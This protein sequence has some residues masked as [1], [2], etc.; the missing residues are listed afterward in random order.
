MSTKRK[1]I[2]IV[3]IIILIALAVLLSFY[4]FNKANDK[5]SM[6]KLLK[7]EEKIINNNIQ[8]N[9]NEEEITIPTEQELEEN[10]D[11]IDNYTTIGILEIPSLNIKYPILSE[12]SNAALKI[13]IAKYWGA[14]PNQVGN[15]VV[16]G[17]N[18]ENSY[19]FS[20]LPNIK[21]GDEIKI[22]DNT[23]K[24]LI[25]KVYETKV[26]DPYDND[27]TSQLTNGR[28]EVTLITCFDGGKNRFY[29]KAY[30]E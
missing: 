9:Q 3:L 24:T 8:S 14:N 30:A 29:A 27:C 12:T 19:M 11:S 20:N 17:H 26:I 16:I 13:S 18:Y 4:Y 22:T 10:E 23:G 1:T 6:K 21:L 28:I 7:N 2:N 15:M 25:Y 5:K